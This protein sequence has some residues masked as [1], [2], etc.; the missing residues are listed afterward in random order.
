MVVDCD[1]K[2]EGLA[3]WWRDNLQVFVMPSCQYFLDAAITVDGKTF[4]LTGTYGEPKMELRKKT[5]DAIHY[6]KS[7]D[8]LITL[9]MCR[10]FQ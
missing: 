1:G 5:W 9:A 7:Q 10:Q 4:R 8:D 6:L 2:S 3:L